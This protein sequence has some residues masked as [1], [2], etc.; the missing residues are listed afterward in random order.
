MGQKSS[1]NEDEARA[2]FDRVD[3]DKDGR[4]SEQELRVLVEEHGELWDMMQVNTG[5]DQEECIRIATAVALAKADTTGS[6]QLEWK[7]FKAM[8]STIFSSPKGNFEF[9]H[10]LLFAAF[11]KDSSG[12]IDLQELDVFLDVFYQAG[13]MFTGDARLPSKD[14]LKSRVLA[15]LDKNGDG[16]LSFEEM[17][18]LLTGDLS[19][20]HLSFENSKPPTNK[21]ASK[22]LLISPSTD[23]M[24]PGPA[25]LSEP[26]RRGCCRCCV[27]Q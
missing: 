6:K 23:E 10:E 24:V 4:I 25:D 15:Q 19:M 1:K 21:S 8:W 16:H 5:I 26:R 14:E 9:F 22:R 12:T 27:L 2:A 3:T 13:G 20:D 18:P 11:D 7:E 17:R